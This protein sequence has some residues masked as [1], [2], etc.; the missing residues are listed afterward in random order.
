M[1]QSVL[2]QDV[3]I[4]R[5]REVV[6]VNYISLIVAILRHMEVQLIVV[7]PQEVL[8]RLRQKVQRAIITVVNQA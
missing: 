1:S 8:L 5:H 4:N 6:T 7:N 3:I 2:N